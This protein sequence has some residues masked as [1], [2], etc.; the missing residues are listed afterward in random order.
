[1]KRL[2]LIFIFLGLVAFELKKTEPISK[3]A[4]PTELLPS[5]S[6][7]FIKET[8]ESAQ[9]VPATKDSFLQL[10]T[11]DEAVLRK[12]FS[13]QSYHQ[14]TPEEFPAPLGT[15]RVY[16]F[17][18]S[19][20]PIQGMVIRLMKDI[21]GRVIEQENTYRPIPELSIDIPEIEKQVADLKE[22][23]LN[24][25]RYQI[26]QVDLDSTVIF[27]RKNL[28]EGQLAFS[29]SAKDTLQRSEPIQLL[30]R[31]TDGKV[32]QKTLGRKDFHF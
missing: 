28:A 24:N 32:L 9:R 21:Q 1:M 7:Q 30:V 17:S 11:D 10:W 20:V 14:I 22:N 8:Q 19:G 5:P 13:I 6:C 4:E 29:L 3:E 2:T 18:Q 16:H 12:K 26:S 31:A 27:V 15:T 25:G 23:S